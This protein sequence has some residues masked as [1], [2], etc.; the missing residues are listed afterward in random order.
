MV[1]LEKSIMTSHEQTTFTF[2]CA[3]IS[4]ILPHVHEEN[5]LATS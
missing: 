1:H 4:G 5:N 3:A 2:V